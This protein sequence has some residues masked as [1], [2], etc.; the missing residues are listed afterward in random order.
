MN[1][2]TKPT[3]RKSNQEMKNMTR[4][5]SK[6]QRKKMMK[7]QNPM[8][9]L[10]RLM[11]YIWKDYKFQMILVLA[12]IL[13]SSITGVIASLFLRTLIDSYITP[14][15]GKKAPDLWVKDR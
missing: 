8:I 11:G 15:L 6:E 13:M 9:P 14:L 4:G 3:Q 7:E 12:C 1:N 5:M 2:E 10:K